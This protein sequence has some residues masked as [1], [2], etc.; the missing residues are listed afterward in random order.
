MDYCSV[1][2]MILHKLRTELPA[3]YF[4]H[5]WQHTWEVTCDAAMLAGLQKHPAP[6][7]ELL[8]TACLFHDCGYLERYDSNESIGADMARKLLPAYG[9]SEADLALIVR[10]IMAT[11]FPYRPQDELEELICDADLYYLLTDRFAVRASL[12]RQELAFVNRV[13]DDLTWLRMER[14]FIAGLTYFTP[15]CRKRYAEVKP[16]LLAAID[17][18]LRSIS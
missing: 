12:L 10:L 15:E 9:Y 8:K 6:F 16:R 11:T 13:Y 17:N 5:N 1:E 7:I 2:R 3:Q 4:F 18:Q 14:D